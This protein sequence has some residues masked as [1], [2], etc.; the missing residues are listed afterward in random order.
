MMQA[1]V[2]YVEALAKSVLAGERRGLAKG[3]TLLES[4]LHA[5]TCQAQALLERILPRTGSSIRVGVTGVPGVGKSTF[6]DALGALL[7]SMG[8]QVAVLAVDPSSTLSGGSI[9]GDKTRMP[10]LAVSE[11]AFVRPSPSRGNL[12]GVARS[13]RE[14]LLL[15]E[16]AGFDVVLVETVGV[17]QSE[18]AVAGMVDV[19][20]LLM[21]ARAG[22][23]LQGIK[24]GILEMADLVAIT[25][26][27]GDNVAH[28]ENACLLYSQALGLLHGNS[29]SPPPR[30]VTL[31]AIADRGIEQVWQLIQDRHDAMRS[32]G[33][34]ERKR[35]TQR[36]TW[37]F[38]TLENAVRSEFF[39]RAGVRLHLSEIAG[40]VERSEITPED[41]A[42][43]LLA[44]QTPQS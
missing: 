33:V 30:V 5:H 16:A 29:G 2:D 28:A 38:D 41:G 15:C 18:V 24:R 11:R 17:G 36:R 8:R 42:A 22:D 14:A 23:E 12:G 35:V 27:D 25:K 43:R 9:L 26:A 40:L 32:D 39:G 21:L 1:D 20:L 31:S 19:F 4:T 3:V 34:L 13:T 44:L 7:I 37:F 6:V 10:R